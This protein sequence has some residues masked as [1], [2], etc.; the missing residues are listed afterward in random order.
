MG[1]DGSRACL[2]AGANDMG[3]TLMNESIS[4]AAGTV[5]G[6]E[7]APAEIDAL[8]A[9]LGRRPRQRT[10][11]YGEASAERRRASLEAPPLAPLKRPVREKRPAA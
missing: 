11:L 7:F 4:R 10:T 1:P 6:E 8:I 5:H 3:G 9:G 2:K